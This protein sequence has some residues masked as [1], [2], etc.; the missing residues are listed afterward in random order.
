MCLGQNSKSGVV[1]FRQP[2]NPEGRWT[3]GALFNLL[4]P[5]HD[6]RYSTQLWGG[7]QGYRKSSK[8][9]DFLNLYM[10]H[11]SNYALVSDSKS[12]GGDLPEFQH[13]RHD[14]SIFSLLVKTH[15]VKTFPVPNYDHPRSNIWA[16]E[17]GYCMYEH[18][19][20][21]SSQFS[22]LASGKLNR[23]HFMCQKQSGKWNLGLRQYLNS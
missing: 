13:H 17:A 8:A 5:T 7:L 14:Q 10:Q 21:I 9:I 4:D 1:G 16:M 3:K 18:W 6:T 22:N 15:G 20:M 12:P 2:C 19:P 11:T 23:M